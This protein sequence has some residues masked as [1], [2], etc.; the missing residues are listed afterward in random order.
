MKEEGGRGAWWWEE[1]AMLVLPTSSTWVGGL[2]LG[3]VGGWVGWVEEEKA[4]G[5]SPTYLHP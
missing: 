5:M 1:E 4:V 2:G 3:W